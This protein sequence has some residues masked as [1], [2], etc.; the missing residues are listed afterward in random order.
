[1]KNNELVVKNVFM[2]SIAQEVGIEPGDYLIKINGVEVKD[3]IE[4]KYLIYDEELNLL[5]R[6]HDGEEWEIEIEKDFEEDLGIEIIDST[7]ENPKRCHNKCMFCFIDQLPP[8]MRKSLYFKDDD[9]KLSFLQ[10]NFITLTNMKDEELE[11]IIRYRISP[12]NISVHT[13]NPDLRIKM[14]HNNKAGRIN[15]QLKKLVDGGILINCQIVLCYGVNDG[16]ELYKTLTDLSSY[17]PSIQNVAVVP[18][19]ITKYREKLVKLEPY[20]KERALQVIELVKP[21][22]EKFLNSLGTPFARL[23][24]EFYVMAEREL[25]EAEHYDDFEQLEDGIGMIRFF[26]LNLYEQINEFNFDAK[27]K[28]I[29]FVTGISF[30][31]KLKDYSKLISDKFN[32][33]IEVFAVT[34]DFFGERITVAGLLTGRDIINQLRNKVAGKTLF[35]PQ[36]VLKADEDTFLDDVTIK[37]IEDTLKTKVIKVKYTGEDLIEKIAKEVV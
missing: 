36:N 13:T 20:T 27:G 3:I 19:G 17:Y 1:M 29:A 21:L 9:S 7:I 31:N 11:R 10:G 34:N 26:E 16:D 25:P 2:G 30:F 15:E 8:N 37:E 23:A 33:N 35:I 4:Y 24:D 18:V 32:L 22:Q 14:L 5:V 28:K 12:I 6:K